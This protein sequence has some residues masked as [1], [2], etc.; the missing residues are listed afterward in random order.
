MLR[1][2]FLLLSFVASLC[3]AQHSLASVAIYYGNGIPL[4]EFKVFD[5]VVVEPGHG[6]DPR[7][8]KSSTS[9]LFAYIS[10]GEANK[11]APYFDLIPSSA[12]GAENKTWGSVVLDQSSAEWREFFLSKVVAPLWAK[13]YKGF[14]IDTMDSY[15]L[16]D[17]FDEQAQQDGVVA[18]I[19]A[20]HARFPG[21]QL[22]VNRGFEVL[23]RLQGKVF[24]IAAE[25]L[26]Q[27]WNAQQKTYE[28]VP[29]SD[30][31]W[32]LN[33]FKVARD[34]YGVPGLSIEYVAPNDRQKMRETASKIKALGLTPWV[35]D[36]DLA[37][38]GMG[39]VEPVPRRIAIIYN[40]K[41][42]SSIPYSNEHRFIEM[43]INYLGYLCEYI[44]ANKP[45][46]P[47]SRD[48]YAG[49][50]TFFAGDLPPAVWPRYQQWLRATTDIG[51]PIAMLG[52]LG[53]PFSNSLASKFGFR[54]ISRSTPPPFEISFQDSMIGLE[55]APSNAVNDIPVLQSSLPGTKSLVTLRNASGATFDGGA[56]TSWG[57][58]L[59]NPFV[60]TEAR[61]AGVV[62]WVV[63][64]FEFLKRALHLAPIPS[65]DPS[66]ENGVRLFLS[67]IDGDGFPSKAEM[68]GDLYA[69]EVLYNE[70]FTKYDL[71][72]SM[73]IIE[74][75]TAPWGLYP[76]L[77]P[78]MER[79][80]RKM[81]QL[82]NIEVASHTFSHPYKWD[83]PDYQ[84]GYSM[85]VP[86]Y[87]YNPHREIVGS[88]D[89]IRERLAPAGKPAELLFWS[90]DTNPSPS[91]VKVATDNGV[92]NIN[93][94]DTSITKQNNSI[95]NIRS[96]G[97]QR[98]GYIQIYAPITNE[99]IYTNLWTGPFY[100]FRTVIETI[101]MTGNPRRIK[102]IG[103]YYHTYSASKPAALTALK[104]VYDWT[105]KQPMNPIFTSEYVRKANDFFSSAIAKDGEYWIVKT[106]GDLRTVRLPKEIGQVHID[107]AH[108]IAG[109]NAGPDGSYVHL[110]NDS[111]RFRTALPPQSPATKP[112]LVNANGRIS[113]WDHNGKITTLS[114]TGHRA[115]TAEIHAP[116]ACQLSIS[117][118]VRQSI[119]G[120]GD[121]KIF[122]LRSPER[123]LEA[124][125]RC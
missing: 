109:S 24:M 84:P 4:D 108:A 63:D 36:G 61:E 75:E 86:G 125:I 76:E 65:P 39:T 116:K 66:T 93:G 104:Q 89:Y 59:W 5:T 43:P 82:D 58:Y 20:M 118:R 6:A 57:G 21:V 54:D 106:Q 68:P 90:G 113:R 107:S 111:G 50:L 95:T 11:S 72:I 83:R 32:L 88:L 100:G 44:D 119:T 27:R 22:I 115:I 46:P 15:R 33:Q 97:L 18:T 69:P 45:L 56:I 117:P 34:Q 51:L 35:A 114:I 60:M 40:S 122:M 121:T 41:E 103:V 101:E 10:I 1:S 28:I 105:L 38:M 55:A 77:S 124:E 12:K 16:L 102:P 62:W 78:R 70:I 48:R 13:G 80:A 2:I 99:N 47:L 29:A 71:P 37:T 42:A 53:M 98:D 87:Q 73:S 81:F 30:R 64:P 31:E 67:H 7:K 112:W 79:I 9:R 110:I 120:N 14:F 49:V 23:P 85:P 96:V 123:S 91:T 25:S 74:A 8:Y 19:N 17:Q 92:L 52:R 26:F 94:G 3:F